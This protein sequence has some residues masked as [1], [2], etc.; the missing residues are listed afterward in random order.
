MKRL[1]K[2]GA[3]LL[4]F[5]MFLLSIGLLAS[6]IPLKSKMFGGV[7]YTTCGHKAV[8]DSLDACRP[9]G[10][11]ENTTCAVQ[12]NDKGQYVEVNLGN[13]IVS[14]SKTSSQKEPDSPNSTN[15]DSVIA[16]PNNPY[17]CDC[18]EYK[19]VKSGSGSQQTMSWVAQNLIAN[20]PTYNMFYTN[21]SNTKCPEKETEGKE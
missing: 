3:L 13:K 6:Y 21:I 2:L 9:S 7:E 12:K 5:G 8:T 20:N 16:Q 1:N 4:L 11:K 15:T 17:N 19:C 10:V 18:I 14:C